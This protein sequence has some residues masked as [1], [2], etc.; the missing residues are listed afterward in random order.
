MRSIFVLFI[1]CI[2]NS[3]NAQSHIWKVEP[4]NW[5]IEMP[6]HNLQLMIYGDEVGKR[7]PVIN[8]EGI[9]VKRYSSDNNINYLF[10]DLV[11]GDL[12]QAL[13]F[14]IKFY[15]EEQ[16]VDEISYS[17]KERRS[18][19]HLI[20]SSLSSSDAIYLINTDRFVNGDVNN[21]RIK[22][23]KDNKVNRSKENS[24][25]GGDIQGV[26][27]QLDYIKDMGF[28]TIS[29][30]PLLV[31]DVED[32]S[33]LGLS[34][35]DMYKIDP[36]FGSNELY[37]NLSFH[38][39]EKGIK[40]FKDIVLNHIGNEHWWMSD[41]PTKNWLNNE[42][43][44]KSSNERVESLF[45]PYASKV[46]SY[47]Y[48]KGWVEEDKPDLNQSNKYL[49]KYLIQN[50]VWWVEYAGL[51]GLRVPYFS[52]LDKG[53]LNKWVVEVQK[54]HPSLSIVADGN[55]YNKSSY[56]LFQK[57]NNQEE[58]VN[59]PVLLK[60]KPSN[61]SYMMDYPLQHSII[62]SFNIEESSKNNNINLLYKNLVNDYLYSEPNN[63]IVFL[64]NN[65]LNRS[66]AQLN[67]DFDYWKMAVSYLMVTRG[68]PQIYYGS[69]V[70][71]SDSLG[72]GKIT[73][74]DLD[75]PGGWR[76]DKVNAFRKD[77]LTQDQKEAQIFLKKML[78]WRKDNEVLHDG[79]LIHFAP[80]KDEELYCLVRYNKEKIVLLFLNSDNKK[81]SIKLKSYINDVPSKAK[82]GIAVNV[83]LGNE[84]NINEKQF[85]EKKSFFLCEYFF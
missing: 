23:L 27:N 50:A 67:H 60:S 13:D 59:Q 20:K 47:N 56:G 42:N 8:H 85:I 19:N 80:T 75:F 6:N 78:A 52:Y 38:C 44:H 40:L 24:R 69:E 4:P 39:E 53:F 34:C 22:G 64:D 11:I 25:H 32:D 21:D 43:E 15:Y 28:T 81:R 54:F 61:I 12:D 62:N 82:N 48:T 70:L 7:R 68:I 58:E 18:V 65:N 83:I 1:F 45:D 5:W 66:F 16:F 35:T 30:N 57:Q 31:N 3:F 33:Y 41:L 51:S 63:M 55:L 71:L 37:K 10:I 26:L 14:N 77:G 76:S 74:Q 2:T 49:S 79:K 73:G 29:I 72:S 36:R 17:L 84:V 9:V 46:D